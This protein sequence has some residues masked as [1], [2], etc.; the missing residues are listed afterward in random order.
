MPILK[1]LRTRAFGTVVRSGRADERA[2]CNQATG[3]T[4]Q[5]SDRASQQPGNRRR[6]AGSRADEQARKRA[7]AEMFI[8]MIIFMTTIVIMIMAFMCIL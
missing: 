1:C 5:P 2:S 4:E 3:A 8:I 7:S 6:Q